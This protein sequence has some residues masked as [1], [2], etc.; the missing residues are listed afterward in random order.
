MA[1]KKAVAKK[2]N[3]RWSWRKLPAGFSNK[4]LLAIG[5][6]LSCFGLVMVYSS[7]AVLGMQKYGDGL[8]F[9]KRQLLPFFVG[10]GLYFLISQISVLKLLKLRLLYLFLSIA[11]LVAVLLPGLGVTAGGAQRWISLVY[12]QFQ[13]SEI[14][15]VFLVFYLASTLALRQDRL[16]SF[17]KGFLPLLIVTSV[18]MFLLILQPDFG[19]AMNILLISLAL[20]FVGGV[21]LSYLGGLMIL[22]L[23]ALLFVLFQASY[24]VQRVM[25]FLDPWK[26][27]QGAGF[28]VIQSYLSFYEGGWSGL[29]LGNSQQKLFYL[30]EAHTDF[31]FSVVGEELGVVGVAFIVLLFAGLL[32]TGARI[33]RKQA[34]LAGYF[35]AIGLTVFL[36]LPALL[37]MF[38]ALGLLPTKGLPLPFISYGR[39]SLMVSLVALGVMQSLS[40]RSE[41]EFS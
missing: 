16:S 9:V 24:R 1:W 34:S 5:L 20:W 37:N 30:P 3:L 36:C 32:V 17:N 10:W 40:S 7:S 25:T 18:L 4:T 23:P 29:G 33:A 39:S 31:I 27:P 13:P 14:V 41:E 35:L 11:L 15:K 12:F 2:S 19:G 28:Q 6:A 26:D 8:Y 38:V 21:S 22:S